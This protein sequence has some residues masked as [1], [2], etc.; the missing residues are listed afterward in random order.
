MADVTDAPVPTGSDEFDIPGD[1]QELADHFGAPSMYAVAN[2]SALPASGNWE[3]RILETA[4]TGNVYIWQAGA[5]ALLARTQTGA[6]VRT[7][8]SALSMTNALTVLDFATS[9]E[10]NGDFSYSAGTFTCIRPGRYQVN[11]QVST[12]IAGAAIG[13]QIRLSKNGAAVCDSFGISST[14]AGMSVD[15]QRTVSLAVG[16]TVDLRTFATTGI[17]VNV[18]TPTATS[19]ELV[20]V[21]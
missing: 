17:G 14:V 2:A 4:D 1:M 15:L 8:T 21:Q 5:W 16:D 19:I 9:V 13:W 3:G 18:S 12:T 10:A 20:R 11:A 7:R 6:T